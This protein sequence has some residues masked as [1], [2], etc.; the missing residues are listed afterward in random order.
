MSAIAMP[1]ALPARSAFSPIAAGVELLD[2]VDFK[3]LMAGEGHCIDLD[4][5]SQDHAYACG[6]LALARGSASAT[7]RSAAARLAQ[8]LGRSPG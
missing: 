1:F 3:W 5:L 6:C 4:R 7:L 2:Y 8:L